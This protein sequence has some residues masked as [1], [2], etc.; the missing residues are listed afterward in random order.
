MR[1]QLPTIAMT[2][3]RGILYFSKPICRKLYASDTRRRQPDR[4]TAKAAR[5]A[6]V[7]HRGAVGQHGQ[8]RDAAWH[9]S[10]GRI[11]RCRQ[12]R[13]R[14]WRQAI[15]PS[16]PRRGSD[17]IWAALL[18]RGTAAFDELK[19]GIRDIEGLADP[20]AGMV[21]VGS[22]ESIAASRSIPPRRP[23]RRHP[24]S[25]QPCRPGDHCVRAASHC[26]TSAGVSSSRPSM[27]STARRTSAVATRTARRRSRAACFAASMH[28]YRQN[29]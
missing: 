25:R 11:C 8:G 19:Q 5:P 4:Q 28:A 17:P 3:Y 7:L 29:Q 22:P 24:R 15:R 18:R 23:S 12:S 1:R 2:G 13:T 9:V 20:S 21:H 10:A 27:T 14:A 26:A 6:P 16:A